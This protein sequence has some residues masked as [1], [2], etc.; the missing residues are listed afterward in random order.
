MGSTEKLLIAL[1]CT[2]SENKDTLRC[3]SDKFLIRIQSPLREEAQTEV[4]DTHVDGGQVL[5]NSTFCVRHACDTKDPKCSW[6]RCLK[7]F[8]EKASSGTEFFAKFELP[9]GMSI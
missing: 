5:Q 2:M 4:S 8:R 9:S 7:V 6:A 1:S 3:I